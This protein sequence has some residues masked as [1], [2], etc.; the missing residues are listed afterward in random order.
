MSKAMNGR[1]SVAVRI[2]G[3]EYK[4]RSAGDSEGLIRIAG[5][6]DRAMD[7]VRERTGTV[8]SLDLAVLTCLNL[9]REILAMRDQLANGP[10][11]ARLRGLIE[12]VEAVVVGRALA[13]PESAGEIALTASDNDSSAP[14]HAATVRNLE[15]P[16]IEDLRD[17]MASPAAAD[18]LP[19]LDVPAPRVA[20]GGRDRNG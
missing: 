14:A 15:L 11:E 1:P 8:A 9:A 19:A 18:G 4:I 17:H 12:Q 16:S 10:D 7:R 6:V 3:H 5:Y 2:A 20:A 13:M